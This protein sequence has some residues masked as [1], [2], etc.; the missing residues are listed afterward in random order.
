MKPSNTRVVIVLAILVVLAGITLGGLTYLRKPRLTPTMHGAKL[1]QEL[2][3]FACHG[4]RGTGGVAN[5]GSEEEEVPAWDG[6]NAMMYVKNEQ[7]IREWILYGHPKR[8]ENEHRHESASNPELRGDENH[9]QDGSNAFPLRMPRFEDVISKKGLDDLVA[10]YKAVAAFETLPEQAREGYQAASRL[11]CFGCHGPGGRIGS[12]N[13]RSFKV[14]I[15]PWHGRDFADLVKNDEELREWILDGTIDRFESSP[16]ARYFT[17]RQVIQMP[18][19]KDALSDREL[20]ALV[21]Y[22]HW[23][24]KDEGWEQAP[25]T[26]GSGTSRKERTRTVFPIVGAFVPI[27]H[28]PNLNGPRY[29]D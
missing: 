12:K 20:D 19:Y 28:S 17:R 15:P 18:A 3:C 4:P 25:A 1:A 16:V 8:L 22:I 7:E 24:Q 23:L 9:V 5:P 26:V 10:F 29:S 13:P 14:Y 27:W 21:A 2:G 6:G 11:G